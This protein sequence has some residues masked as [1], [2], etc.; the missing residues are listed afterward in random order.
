MQTSV[1]SG[2]DKSLFQ[3]AGGAK[4]PGAFSGLSLSG[5]VRGRKKTP[6]RA[7]KPQVKAQVKPQ[8]K[9]PD[10]Q[11]EIEPINVKAR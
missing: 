7:P 11:F 6:L 8:A 9:S 3:T 2:S 4:V 1:G 10:A 5:Q